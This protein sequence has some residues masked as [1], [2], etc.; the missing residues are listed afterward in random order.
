VHLVPLPG[1]P[2][3]LRAAASDLQSTIPQLRAAHVAAVRLER[4]LDGDHWR[5][6]AFEAFTRVVERK[7]LPV[8]LDRAVDRIGQAAEHL[9]AYAAR[10]EELQQA[11]AHLRAR[12][13]S[14]PA[15]GPDDAAAAEAV[16]A[17]LRAIEAQARELHDDHRRALEEVA[18]TFGWLSEEPTFAEPPPSA[19]ERATGALGGL[20]DVAW[21]FGTGVVEGVRDMALGIYDLGRLLLTPSGWETIL[22]S[23][24]EVWAVLQYAWANPGAFLAELGSALLD[25]DTL[26]EDPA[27]WLGRRVPDLLLAVATM[28][29]GTVGARAAASVR[30]VRT[31]RFAEQA[32][33]RPRLDLSPG[34]AADRL[35]GLDG[36]A[37]RYAGLGVDEGRLARVD[38]GALARTDTPLG[39][40]ATEVDGRLARVPGGTSLR[41]APGIV[42]D[43][44]RG[45]TD[46]PVDV[47]LDRLG[48][49]TEVRGA[50]WV[51]RT[52]GNV[53][54]GGL[55]NQLG[56]ADGLL[57][58]APALSPLAYGSIATVQAVS[59]LDKGADVHGAVEAAL[60]VPGR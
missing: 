17:E 45:V 12:A 54:T 40:L 7:P 35:G 23:G 32:F 47:A 36:M 30:G 9:R 57:V 52:F 15:P 18:G 6:E 41:Q 4:L 29:A 37:G 48:L 46:R 43:E 19:W 53:V 59:L 27:R 60:T 10:L 44:I 26:R 8:A 14:V 51:R 56:M 38:G 5:G 31:A 13:A 1:D 22:S 55:T 24:D 58:G 2:G 50:P 16:A 42:L 20:V 11:M 25:L 34:A 39:R 21:S 3:A 49:G 28:G 33:G